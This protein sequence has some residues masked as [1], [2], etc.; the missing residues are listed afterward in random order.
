VSYWPEEFHENNFFPNPRLRCRE[1]REELSIA[2]NPRRLLPYLHTNLW[3]YEHALQHVVLACYECET[4]DDIPASAEKEVRWFPIDAIDFTL[5]LPGTRE[6]IALAGANGWFDELFIQFDRID[7]VSHTANR[8]TI[9]TQ[10][11]LYSKYGLVKYWGRIGVFP[12]T[13]TEIFGSPNELDEEIFK[14]QD[15]ALRMDIR[16]VSSKVLIS[17]ISC[18]HA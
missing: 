3:E 15:V 1:I 10:P 14:P 6:F 9:A 13:K 8:F 17:Q 2:V 7:R 11:T 16:S 5:T 4:Y 12:R 18:W